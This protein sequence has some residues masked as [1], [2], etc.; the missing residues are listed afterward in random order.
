MTPDSLTAYLH[1]EIPLTRA[2]DLAVRVIDAT[3][4]RLCAP[5]AA[6]IN[7]HDTAFGGSIATIGILAGWSMLH[8][9][10][11]EARIHAGI[12]IQNSSVSYL[13]PIVTDLEATCARPDPAGWEL[14]VEMLHRGKIARIPLRSELY[15]RGKIAAVHDGLYVASLP[16]QKH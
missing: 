4:V 10:L 15:C 6:N 11:R 8:I 2:M 12:V 1:D 5:L 14:F 7:H 13:R 9:M 3:G 16:S